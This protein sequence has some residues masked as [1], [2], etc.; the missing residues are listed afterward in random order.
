MNVIAESLRGKESAIKELTLASKPRRVRW[1]RRL[2]WLALFCALLFVFRHPLMTLAARCWILDEPLEKADA[3]IVLGGNLETR[4]LYASEAYRR[5]LVPLVLVTDVRTGPAVEMKIV[6][7]ETDTAV[8]ILQ[9]SGVPAAV[10]QRIGH[11]VGSTR[12]EAVAAREWLGQHPAKRLIVATDPFHTRRVRYIFEHEL[13]GL[14]VELSVTSIPPTRYDPLQW[15][16]SEEATLAFQNEVL[17][18]VYYWLQ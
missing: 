16:K 18:L 6:P 15:W 9:K 11:G 1:L 2:V 10:I 3:A 7:S 12:D 13:K 4:P 5:G 14:P 17:K 8:N